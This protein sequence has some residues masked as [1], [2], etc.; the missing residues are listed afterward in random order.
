MA[1]EDEDRLVVRR[2]VSPVALP[3]LVAPRS[4]P[5]TEHVSTH[6]GGADVAGYP[7]RNRC[8][9]VDLPAF[10]SMRFAKGFER[11]EPVVKL[12]PPSP[13]GS[14]SAW[15]VPATKPSSD[16]VMLTFNFLIGFVLSLLWSS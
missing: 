5:A 4:R 14:F 13:S 2:I 8:A 3:R 10:F 6:D 9:R 12:H 1:R 11:N 7:L 15:F 16:I